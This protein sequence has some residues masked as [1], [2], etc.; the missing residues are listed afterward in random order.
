M[1]QGYFDYSFLPQE[2]AHSVYGIYNPETL[3]RLAD[4][5]ELHFLE[6][7][8]CRKKPIGEMS[9]LEKWMSFFANVSTDDEKEE[10]AMQEPA[11]RGA[12]DAASLF[13]QDTEQYLQY[14]NRQMAI[15]DYN[16]DMNV[17]REEGRLEG[18]A[19]ERE[20]MVKSLL[21][22]GTPTEYIIKAFGMTEEELEKYKR[23]GGK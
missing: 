13:M 6:I 21:A 14:V 5:M 8:K 20:N 7:A 23:I 2:A 11:I 4:C 1:T 3:H 22:A 16:T 12:M 17:C 15:Y 9:R 18:S 10:L 19:A